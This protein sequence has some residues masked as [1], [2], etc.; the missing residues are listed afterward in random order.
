MPGQEFPSALPRA[1]SQG[2]A[3]A[4]GLARECA[5]YRSEW[6][7][8]LSPDPNGELRFEFRGQE[9][10]SRLMALK[11]VCPSSLHVR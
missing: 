6:H 11:Q 2:L 10:L 8:G 3:L 1:Q 5:C 7:R 9:S 4:S